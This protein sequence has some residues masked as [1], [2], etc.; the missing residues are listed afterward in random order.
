MPLLN[1]RGWASVDVESDGR[2]F[3]FVTTHLE[4]DHPGIRSLQAMEMIASAGNTSLPL[5]FVGDFN[6]S[7]NPPI[8]PAYGQFLAAGFVDAWTRK[9][10]SR[11]GLTCCHLPDL[12]NPTSVGFFDQRIDLVL[13]RGDFRVEDIRV[14]GEEPGDRTR[15]GLWPSDHAGVIA[16]LRIP[17]R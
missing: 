11:P 1:L 17:R 4:A 14:V 8:D 9:H 15:S 12:S 13:F 10:P 2:R 6:A 5:V 16:T 7:A 3:R